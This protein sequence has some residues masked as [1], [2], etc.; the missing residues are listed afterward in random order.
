MITQLMLNHH[1][2][3]TILSIKHR[4]FYEKIHI[5][6]QNMLNHKDGCLKITVWL[7]KDYRSISKNF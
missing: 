6:T 3:N 7:G 4:R 1:N 5:H 2:E